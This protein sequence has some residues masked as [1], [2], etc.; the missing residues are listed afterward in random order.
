MHQLSCHS[1]QH[2]LL[3]LFTA[4]TYTHANHN[5]D[6]DLLSVGI[7]RSVG[8]ERAVTVRDQRVEFL[9]PMFGQLHSIGGLFDFALSF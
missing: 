6:N 1:L 9:P 8:T 4:N 2:T 7:G 3:L 5:T